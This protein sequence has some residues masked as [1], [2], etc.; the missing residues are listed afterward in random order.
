M[1]ENINKLREEVWL[2]LEKIADLEALEKFRVKYLGKKGAITALLRS[3]GSLPKEER[4]LFGKAVNEL[5]TEVE[6]K[7]EEKEAQLMEAKRARQLAEEALDVT[8]PGRAPRLGHRHP[9][10]QVME[11]IEEIF[12]NMGYTIAD[13]REVEDDFHNFEA[14][15]IPK[16]HPS[17]DMQDTFWISSDTLIRTH[18]SSVQSR[19]MEKQ[20]PPVRIIAPGRVYRCDDDVTHSPMFHQ[21]EGLVVDKGITF[22]DLKWTLTVFIKA[23]FGQERQVRFRP[24]YFPF[25]EPSCEVDVSCFVCNGKG[26]RL[27]KNTGWIEI[28][29]AGM[30]HP[31]VLKIAG[32]DTKVYTGFAFGLGIERIAMLRYGIDDIRLFYES[33]MRF[34][35]QF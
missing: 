2:E 4:P 13:G 29:G 8:L 23:L 3:M 33:D 30:V 17:R 7:L 34:L 35:S 18:T 12:L 19:V 21:V 9:L 1:N 32:Y 24:S 11:E 31:N 5:S 6:E 25:T 22:G 28:L 27:C 15:N 16:D 10:K 14:L 20:D 26:C